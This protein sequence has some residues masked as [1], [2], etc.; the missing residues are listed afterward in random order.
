ALHTGNG[1]NLSGYSNPQ[2]D[3]AIG[4]LA[5]SADAAERVRLLAETA[6]I[7]WGDMPTLPLYRQQRTLLMSK[8][9]YA[10]SNNPTR[11]GV[12]WNMDRW[13]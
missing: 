3:S 4:A 13:A 10:V 1:N 7:L 8:K 9:M 2:G 5:V 12:G 6:P 11:W